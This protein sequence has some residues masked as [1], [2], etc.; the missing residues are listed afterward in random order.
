[1]KH[2]VHRSLVPRGKITIHLAL[3]R[4][5]NFVDHSRV[6]DGVA[7]VIRELNVRCRSNAH[8]NVTVIDVTHK[9]IP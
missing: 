5:A 9:K 6:S 1:M 2:H 8:L 3:S 7:V 4:A